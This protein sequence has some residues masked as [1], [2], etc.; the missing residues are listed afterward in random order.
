MLTVF[1]RISGFSVN[2]SKSELMIMTGTQLMQQD[3]TNVVGCQ[4][5]NNTVSSTGNRFTTDA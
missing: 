1:Q 3:L 4:L 5:G 2:L